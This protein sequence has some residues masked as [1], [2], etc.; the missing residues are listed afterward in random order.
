MF[1][2]WLYHRVLACKASSFSSSPQKTDKYTCSD[3]T[4]SD[5]FNRVI[6]LLREVSVFRSVIIWQAS[7]NCV[8]FSKDHVTRTEPRIP[9]HWP[10]TPARTP[11]AAI[12]CRGLLLSTSAWRW[13]TGQKGYRERQAIIP[14]IHGTSFC[15]PTIIASIPISL[16]RFRAYFFVIFLI[17]PALRP[18]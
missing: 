12:L 10:I 11:Q 14:T 9:S 6:T 17:S 2:Y 13:L 16:A 15:V 1:L 8:V 4:M 18:S 7:W 5:G 3:V